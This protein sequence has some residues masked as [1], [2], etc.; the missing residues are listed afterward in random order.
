MIHHCVSSYHWS[1][2]MSTPS[3]IS[4]KYTHYLQQFKSLYSRHHPLFLLPLSLLDLH[5][6]KYCVPLSLNTQQLCSI[7]L[8]TLKGCSI[9]FISKTLPYTKMV[10]PIT[11]HYHHVQTI[12]PEDYIHFFYTSH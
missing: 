12:T 5:H 4:F 11:G 7:S 2:H 3:L 1:S 8:P 10:C 9:P 6:N